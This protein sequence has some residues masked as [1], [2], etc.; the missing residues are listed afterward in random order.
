MLII[1]STV[2]FECEDTGYSIHKFQT[3]GNKRPRKILDASGMMVATQNVTRG[4][5]CIT[6]RRCQSLRLYPIAS[7]K[8]EHVAPL[9]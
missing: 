1:K 4:P 7:M 8:N 3:S 6:E 2:Q 5:F 9:E